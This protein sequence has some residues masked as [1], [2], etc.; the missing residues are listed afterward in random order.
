MKRKL[1]LLLAIGSIFLAIEARALVM[2]SAS[3]H[4]SIEPLTHGI[5][6]E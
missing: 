3:A 1:A 5:G 6:A 2:Q 4:S